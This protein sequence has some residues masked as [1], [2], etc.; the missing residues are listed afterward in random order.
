[1]SNKLIIGTVAKPQGVRGEL[2]IAPLTDDPNRFN[3]LKEVSIKGKSYE[4][5]DV[6]ILPNGVFLSLAGIDDRDKAELLRGQELSV[7]RTDAVDLPEDRYFIVDVIGCTV[8]SLGN[9]IGKIKNV[10]QYG[11]ADIYV[12]DTVDKKRAMIPA[13]D[14]VIMSIDIKSKCVEIDKQAY[15]DLVVYED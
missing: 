12:I 10:L 2:K 5:K 15:E 6:R 4:V 11:S 8:M 14:R 3:K 9:T 13:I 7:D 1:M